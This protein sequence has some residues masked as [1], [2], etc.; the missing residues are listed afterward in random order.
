MDEFGYV[1][2]STNMDRPLTDFSNKCNLSLDFSR[3]PVILGKV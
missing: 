1:V 2:G 3:P